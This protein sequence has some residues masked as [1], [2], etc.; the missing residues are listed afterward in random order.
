MITC[1]PLLETLMLGIWRWAESCSICS[2]RQMIDVLI[3]G[4]WGRANHITA[5]FVLLYTFLG[6]VLVRLAMVA[7]INI[8]GTSDIRR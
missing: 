8:A 4:I 7:M 5:S 2:A 1:V 6:S 3:I